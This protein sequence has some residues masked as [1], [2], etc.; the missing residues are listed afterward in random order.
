MKK[1]TVLALCGLFLCLLLFGCKEREKEMSS[2]YWEAMDVAP[3]RSGQ[4]PPN[5][6]KTTIKDGKNMFDVDQEVSNKIGE[7]LKNHPGYHVVGSKI[8]LEIEV[9]LAPE[10]ENGRKD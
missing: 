4:I 8:N 6:W 3:V 7:L 9:T 10:R 2:T 5:T 1:L